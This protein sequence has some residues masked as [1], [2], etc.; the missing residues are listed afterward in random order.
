[1]G[2]IIIVIYLA[3]II[4]IIAGFWK[5]FEKAGQPGWAAIVP[6]YN[7]I[8]LIKIS[9]RPLWWIVL[10]LI[11]IVSIVAAIIIS[12]DVAKNFGKGTGFGIGLALL[13][14][15]FYPILGFGDAEYNPVNPPQM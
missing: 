14:F 10:F 11:P 8:V 4:A 2:A 6:I 7:V 5:T 1:M 3:L 12:I 13:G 9:G 15:I